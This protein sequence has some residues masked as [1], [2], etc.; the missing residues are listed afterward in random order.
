MNCKSAIKIIKYLVLL[1]IIAAIALMTKKIGKLS[2]ENSRLKDNQEILILNNNK[3]DAE[4]RKYKV[5]DSLNAYKASELRLRL[6]EYKKYR[7]EDMALIRKLK[8]DKANMQKVIDTRASTIYDLEAKLKD[9]LIADTTNHNIIR[10]DSISIKAFS[11]KSKWVDVIGQINLTENK[12][13]L[14]IH[15][16]E[17]LAVVESIEYKRFLGF[18]W[19]TK[20]IKK[21]DVD[22]VSKNPNTTIINVDYISLEN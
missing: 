9:S 11:Y 22:I 19:K 18:L 8:V 1:A 5:S 17:D 21:K 6:D 12:V 4:C 7:S 10:A 20:R 16:R 15:S 2:K 13:N 3:L 14:N